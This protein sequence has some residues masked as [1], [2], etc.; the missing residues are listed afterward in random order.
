MDIVS[1]TA[2]SFL[3]SEIMFYVRIEFGVL[4]Q[5]QNLRWVS[6]PCTAPFVSEMFGLSPY[7]DDHSLITLARSRVVEEPTKNF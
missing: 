3:S 4:R 7:S 2:P 5:N 1:F 6:S